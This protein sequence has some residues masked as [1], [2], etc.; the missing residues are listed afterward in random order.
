MARTSTPISSSK[1]Q[2]SVRYCPLTDILRSMHLVTSSLFLPSL[3][4]HLTP[5]SQSLLLRSYFAVCL[6]WWVA[7]GRAGFDIPKFFAADTA[8]PVTG[9]PVP[10]PH[11][12]A[13]PAKGSAKAST[14]NAWLPIVQNSIVMPD[15][16]LPKLQ[17]ALAHYGTL[18]GTRT[19]GLS[20]FL[21]TELEGAEK[22]D[23]TLFLRAAGL[24]NGK[25]AGV[26]E[27][28]SIQEKLWDLVGFF[29]S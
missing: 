29:K 20:D 19:A 28:D 25:L 26:G 15:D 21:D 1:L 18:Y 23:G 6:T 8:H 22:L 3:V 2:S 27:D 13:L 14:P 11:P 10:P 5:A 16:H 24:T 9:G 7:R 12:K 4:A 17:R